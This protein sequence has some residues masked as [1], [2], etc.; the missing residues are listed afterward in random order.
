MNQNLFQF[1]QGLFLKPKALSFCT[2]MILFLGCFG[3]HPHGRPT[4]RLARSGAELGLHPSAASQV[5]ELG[6]LGLS[7]GLVLSFPCQCSLQQ[8][9][10]LLSLVFPWEE[11]LVWQS[12]PGSWFT[13]DAASTFVSSG[14]GKC[15]RAGFV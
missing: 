14:M 8:E 9:P 6:T 11:H 10:E 13:I 12:L 4:A 7:S 1:K 2:L 15:P 3:H 5:A